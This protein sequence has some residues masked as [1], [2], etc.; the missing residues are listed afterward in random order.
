MTTSEIVLYGNWRSSSSQRV[1]IGLRLKQLSFSYQPIDLTA[2]EQQQPAFRQIHPGAQVPV[3]VIDGQVISQSLA[4]LEA[5]E[6][7]FPGVGQRLLPEH[8]RARCQSREI[9]LFVT[10]MMQPFQ[11]PGATRR[12]M[13]EDFDLDHPP[14][15]A[16]QACDRFTRHHLGATLP[17]LERL[18]ARQAGTFCLGDQ[19]SLADCTVFPQLIAASRFGLDINQFASLSRIYQHCLTVPAFRESQ[20][21]FLADAPTAVATT[22]PPPTRP[23]LTAAS[24]DYKEPSEATRQYLLTVNP[25]IPQWEWVRAE[26]FRH[27]GPITTKVTALEVC[28]LLRWLVRTLQARTVIEVG[29]FTGSSSLALLDGL[30]PQGRLMAFDVSPDYTAIAQQAWERAGFSNQVDLRLE[31][32]AQ[33]LPLLQRDAR[34][35]GQVNL[36]Y[37]DGLNSQYHQNYEDLLPLMARGGVI[38]LDNVLWK[39]EVAQTT[40][41]QHPDTLALREVNTWVSQDPRVDCTLLSLGDGLTLATLK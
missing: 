38:V 28:F 17:E 26:T 32:A 22:Q 18:V 5:L 23:G 3:L 35:V 39:G 7:Y 34:M 27:F 31:D 2:R 10:S 8:P 41:P 16:R 20:P 6:E 21:E 29:V 36:A 37:V 15:R 33:G 12:R 1:Q 24:L 11:L 25:P 4:I 19:P 40:A 30:G 13:V 9:A 14:G